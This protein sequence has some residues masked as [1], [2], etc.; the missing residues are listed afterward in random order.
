MVKLVSTESSLAD[1]HD[2]GRV[3]T[4]LIH[5]ILD[6]GQVLLRYVCFLQFTLLFHEC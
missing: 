4:S 3:I 1:D 6:L 2:S 5:D